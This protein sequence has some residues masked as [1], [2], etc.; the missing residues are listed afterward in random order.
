MSARLPIPGSDDNTWGN[1]LNM[2]LDVSHNS[3]G[4]LQQNAIE[5]AGAITA[6]NSKAAVNGSVSLS[7]SDVG[8]VTLAETDSRYIAA[9]SPITALLTDEGGQAFNV[10]AYGATGNGINDDT[11]AFNRVFEAGINATI[12]IPQGTYILTPGVLNTFPGNTRLVGA[13]MGNTTLKL[14][15]GFNNS[16]DLLQIVSATNAEL[17][18][19]TLDGNSTAQIGSAKQYGFYLSASANCIVRS[20]EAKNWTGDGIQLY[21]CTGCMIEACYSHGNGY[22]GFEIEQCTNC[23]VS[24]CRGYANTVHGLILTPGEVNSNGSQGNHV[25]ACSFDSNLQY[26]ICVNW[27]NASSGAHLSEGNIISSNSITNNAQYGA[28][29]YGE[30]HNT[31]TDN[32]VYNNGYFGLY[33]YQSA[34]NRIINNYFHNNS[35]ILNGGYDEIGLEGSQDGYASSYNTVAN[36]TFLINGSNKAR[37]AFNE[38]SA[39]DGPNIVMSNVVPLSG[40][41]GTYNIENTGTQLGPVDMSSTQV[42]G[43]AKSFSSTVVGT[44]GYAVAANASLASGQMGL[45]APFGSAA[46]RLYNPNSSGNVQL[47]TPNGT[48]NYYV[49]GNAV[50]NFTSGGLTINDGYGIT[51]G[52]SSGL[53]IGTAVNQR[54]GFFN[55]VPVTQPT[56]TGVT[57]GYTAGSEAS[58]TVDGSFT[59]TLGTT[60]YTIGD[61]VGALKS[62]G[63]LAP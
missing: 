48:V 5:Q 42:I 25:M 47:V 51:A 18:G 24:D 3:D 28:C 41:A 44:Q 63:L 27:D 54:L 52:T 21:D 34:Y 62:L 60:K 15:D 35:S 11:A 50:A 61:I 1:I 45:D 17:S 12:Y 9:G 10:K 59:G 40:V 58:V 26:G 31:F 43:G 33:I 20:I 46:L 37:Y 38:L 39:G 30:S 14:V 8:A 19:F 22:H 55:T 53:K 29:F 49:G 7:A 6:I 36:N 4:S 57:S 13:G 16:G 23:T 56:A 32:Y 2:F